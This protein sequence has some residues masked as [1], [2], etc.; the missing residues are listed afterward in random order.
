MLFGDGRASFARMVDQ[1]WWGYDYTVI[2]FVK[3]TMISNVMRFHT[4][5]IQAGNRGHD[6]GC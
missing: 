1:Q 2:I 4:F 6:E 3:H 5:C